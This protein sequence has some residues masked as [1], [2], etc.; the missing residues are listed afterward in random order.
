MGAHEGDRGEGE[1]IE[2]VGV[3]SKSSQQALS[4]ADA[5]DKCGQGFPNYG[6]FQWSE[7]DFNTYLNDYLSGKETG[8][9]DR[10]VQ[11]LFSLLARGADK[12]CSGTLTKEEIEAFKSRTDNPNAVKLADHIL[13]NYDK[14][15]S[16]A[17][18]NWDEIK[19]PKVKALMEK[20]LKDGAPDNVIS[21]KDLDALRS[22]SEA[23][24]YGHFGILDTAYGEAQAK[25][26]ERLT[27]NYGLGFLGLI[28][29]HYQEKTKTHDYFRFKTE[30]DK[31]IA[32]RTEILDWK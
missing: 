22:M 23:S 14:I 27:S 28:A 6:G 20:Y 24:T 4:W 11:S 12:D 3:V 13:K 30:I 5:F 9:Q 1:R 7:K 31:Q 29:D 16:F 21:A 15:A 10:H 25:D 19:D 17:K 26:R 2:G 18:S 8:K 32:R